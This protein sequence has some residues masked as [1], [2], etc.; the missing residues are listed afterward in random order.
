MFCPKCGVENINGS[1]ICSS[2]SCLLGQ[3]ATDAK[4]SRLAIASLILAIICVFTFGLTSLPAIIC[5]IIGLVKISKSKGQL[6]GRGLAIAGLVIPVVALPVFFVIG[7]MICFSSM[8]RVDSYMEMADDNWQVPGNICISAE[9]KCR[10]LSNYC[11]DGK[12]NFL[13]CDSSDKVVRVINSDDKLLATWKLDFSPEAIDSRAD[14]TTIVAGAG[15]AAILDSEGKVIKQAS[16]PGSKA[17]GIGYSGEDIFIAVRKGTGYSVY[18]M[19]G[20]LEG[21]TQIIEGLRGC[22]GQMDITSKDGI[23]YVAANTLFKVIK[24]DRT[25]KEVDRFGKKGRSGDDTFKGCCEPKNVCFDSDGNLYTSESDQCCVKKFTAD[26]KFIEHIGNVSGIR[27]CVR[28]SVAVSK[29]KSRIYMLDTGKNII[30]KVPQKLAVLE[31]TIRATDTT[32]R[33]MDN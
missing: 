6:K 11:M 33:A 31:T 22:C 21:Q 24:Y 10:K 25:G 14:G 27:G 7:M 16:I 18:R 9:T 5:A 1:E 26:G 4:T 12:D 8:S 23:V 30:R 28:V 13:A 15:K 17:T 20:Q 2:C 29:D 3:E 19:D 32:T